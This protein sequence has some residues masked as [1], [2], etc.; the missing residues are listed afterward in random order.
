MRLHPQIIELLAEI[1]AFRRDYDI[2][3]TQ[4]GLQ[5]VGDG[6]FIRALK[7]GREPMLSTLDRARQFMKK[8]KHV[9]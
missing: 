6:N 7:Q 4:F 3:V 1:E 5:A 9:A 8:Y 2:S